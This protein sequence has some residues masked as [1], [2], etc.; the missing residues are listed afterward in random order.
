MNMNDQV[1]IRNGRYKF[2]QIR[3]CEYYNIVGGIERNK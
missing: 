1:G 3:Y 2:Y